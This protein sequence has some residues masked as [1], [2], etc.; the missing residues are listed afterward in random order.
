MESTREKLLKSLVLKIVSLRDATFSFLCHI[1]MQM[2]IYWQGWVF[3]SPGVKL[4]T[5]GSQS[6]ALCKW[7]VEDTV[8]SAC[9]VV[10]SN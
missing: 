3:F 6:Q 2:A 10:I 9:A 5:V 7:L 1:K 4:E 8:L